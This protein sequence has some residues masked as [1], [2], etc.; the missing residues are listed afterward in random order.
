MTI[1]RVVPLLFIIMNITENYNVAACTENA[2][3]LA[4][5]TITNTTCRECT[6]IVGFLE[7]EMPKENRTTSKLTR[8]ME[9]ICQHLKT[10][11]GIECRILADDIRCVFEYIDKGLNST[12]VCNKLRF[13]TPEIVEQSVNW[14]PVS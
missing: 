3:M 6:F 2:N 11:S 9:H 5:P 12:M 10:P 4:W 7:R 14:G 1:L 8:L 13:C